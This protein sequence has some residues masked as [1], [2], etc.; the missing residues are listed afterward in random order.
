VLNYGLDRVRFIAPVRGARV[1]NRIKLIS[2]EDKGHGR[3]L[4]ST[5]NTIE[6]EGEQARADR[7]RMVMPSTVEPGMFSR[8]Q[9]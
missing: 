3:T 2:A 4:I 9:A 1:R 8:R 5:E 7:Q 6:I